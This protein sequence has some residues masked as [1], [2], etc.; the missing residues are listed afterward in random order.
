MAPMADK[1]TGSKALTIAGGVLLALAVL[2]L[3]WGVGR[4]TWLNG[5][6]G[7]LFRVYTYLAP[8]VLFALVAYVVWAGVHGAFAHAKDATQAA[9][10][11][12]CSLDDRRIAG[13]CGGIASHYRIDSVTVRV[14]ALGL[15]VLLPPLAC[16]VY[17]VAALVLYPRA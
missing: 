14:I 10:P 3:V 9:S 4:F 12:A 13:L 8:V 1:R 11:L 17:L 5:I 6:V 7:V 15:F 16:I 2:W